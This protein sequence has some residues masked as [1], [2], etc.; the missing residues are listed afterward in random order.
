MAW[1][2]TWKPARRGAAHRRLQHL[3]GHEA[4]AAIAGVVAIVRRQPRAARAQRAV[5]EQLDRHQRQPVV[6]RPSD[7]SAGGD[8]V[9]RV[10][11]SSHRIDARGELAAAV[12]AAVARPVS[13]TDPGVADAGQPDRRHD[14]QRLG[15]LR[16][17][18]GRARRRH[19]LADQ[20]PRGID[21]HPGGR[22]AGQ[23]LDTAVG[24]VRGRC[25]DACQPHRRA[26]R[27]AGVAVDAL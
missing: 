2:L 12:E 13:G 14:L 5:G 25:G 10:D 9:E 19:R 21:E 17:A 22:A 1:T 18:L 15:E 4:Q 20:R 8:R 24:G 26:V 7:R 16:V 6:A 3:G 11:T 27:P 23:P